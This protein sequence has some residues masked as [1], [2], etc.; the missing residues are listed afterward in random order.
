VFSLI[1][2]SVANLLRKMGAST[3]AELAGLVRS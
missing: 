2:R 3:R 1:P